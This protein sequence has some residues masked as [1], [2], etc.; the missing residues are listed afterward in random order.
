MLFFFL[1]KAHVEIPQLT[2]NKYNR[3]YSKMRIVYYMLWPGCISVYWKIWVGRIR[4]FFLISQIMDI[5][6]YFTKKLMLTEGSIYLGRYDL[7]QIQKIYHLLTSHFSNH[8]HMISDFGWSKDFS[9][10]LIR[11]TRSCQTLPDRRNIVSIC[12]L[13]LENDGYVSVTVH[14]YIPKWMLCSV[15]AS[16]FVISVQPQ[17]LSP[18]W[19]C[20]V[21]YHRG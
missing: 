1:F 18:F 14:T 8:N 15:R 17:G 7:L 13:K 11:N 3:V 6:L 4:F 9:W 10:Y 21:W 12:L 19:V 5:H 20:T 16:F 2:R